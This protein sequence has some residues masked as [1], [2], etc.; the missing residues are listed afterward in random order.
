LNFLCFLFFSSNSPY[1]E[2]FSPFWLHSWLRHLRRPVRNVRARFHNAPQHVFGISCN[3]QSPFRGICFAYVKPE[4]AHAPLDGTRFAAPR[5]NRNVQFP[6]SNSVVVSKR[7]DDLIYRCV[8]V[9]HF[10]AVPARN[11][12]IHFWFNYLQA[13]SLGDPELIITNHVMIYQ[14]KQHYAAKYLG[15][16]GDS[17]STEGV[18]IGLP[19]PGDVDRHDIPY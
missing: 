7:G 9:T 4:H 18:E 13:D 15:R 1:S 17:S 8:K 19:P 5:N 11:A 16:C 10:S 2:L 14:W 3:K 12:E 6:N